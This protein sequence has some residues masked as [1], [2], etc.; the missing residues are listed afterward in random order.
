MSI[1]ELPWRTTLQYMASI[2]DLAASE[3]LCPLPQ[4]SPGH[5]KGPSPKALRTSLKS[6]NCMNWVAL[7]TRLQTGKLLHQPRLNFNCP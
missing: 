6:Q 5:I 4:L 2:H 7:L 3:V 1:K